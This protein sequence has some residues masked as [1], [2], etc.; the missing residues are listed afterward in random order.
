MNILTGVWIQAGLLL[1]RRG[2][3]MTPTCPNVYSNNYYNFVSYILWYINNEIVY[4]L[5]IKTFMYIN[6]N[7]LM[8]Y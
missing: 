2:V 3:N 8:Y 4:L 5:Y 7:I 1:R 6:V